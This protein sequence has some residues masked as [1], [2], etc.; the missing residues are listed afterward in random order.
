MGAEDT[1]SR[2]LVCS[3]E[4][5]D[6]DKSEECG[7]FEKHVNTQHNPLMYLYWMFYLKT[8]PWEEKDGMQLY[9]TNMIVNEDE[10]WI[11]IRCCVAMQ[12]HMDTSDLMMLRLDEILE[13]LRR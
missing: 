11:P 13:V 1:Q 9:T 8:K 12:A 5:L 4:K 7:G 6:C 2:C 3:L 10:E